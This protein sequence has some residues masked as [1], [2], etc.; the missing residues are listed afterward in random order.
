MNSKQKNEI[1]NWANTLS[2]EKLESEYY[3]AVDDSL[4]SK[5]E[6]MRDLGYDVQDISE[7]ASCE[8]YIREKSDLL[9]YLCQKRG[10]KLWEN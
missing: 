3:A 8:K 5:A 7:Q 1:T 4:G 6:Q 10:I 9:E 2:D